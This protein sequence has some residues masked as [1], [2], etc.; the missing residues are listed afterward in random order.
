VYDFLLFLHV[1]TAVVW[2]GGGLALNFLGTRLVAAG[3]SAEIAGFAR[4]VEWIGTRVFMP[5]S[6]VLLLAG[7]FMTIDAWSFDELWIAI[8]MG[9][10]LYSFINGAFFVGPLSGRTGKLISEK[11]AD[12]PEISANIQRIF[13]LGRIELAVLVI[14]VWAMTM[15]PTL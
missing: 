1:L 15:K 5:S 11:G 8:G 9:G 13:F 6:L 2:V 7:I 12:D 10:F 3:T 4:Q 14:V